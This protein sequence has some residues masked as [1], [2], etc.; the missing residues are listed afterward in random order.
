MLDGLLPSTNP[1]SATIASTDATETVRSSSMTMRRPMPLRKVRIALWRSPLLRGGL[2]ES[3]RYCATATAG[4]GV[5]PP[6]S[7][8]FSASSLPSV[9]AVVVPAAAD[10]DGGAETASASS[11]SLADS[12]PDDSAPDDA[13]SEVVWV[14]R[15]YG[16]HGWYGTNTK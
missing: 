16:M 9:A 7:S 1:T 13:P 2:Y 4:V 5:S 11:I 12:P 15:V 3:R 6:P 14:V 10:G 8:S